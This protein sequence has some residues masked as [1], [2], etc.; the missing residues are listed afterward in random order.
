[1]CSRYNER[2]G[3][4]FASKSPSVH[5]DFNKL[6]EVD[7][8][9]N[10][11]TL[12]A[13]SPFQ[14]PMGTPRLYR[15]TPSKE[16]TDGVIRRE[17]KKSSFLRLSRCSSLIGSKI[18]LHFNKDKGNAPVSEKIKYQRERNS[19][20]ELDIDRDEPTTSC[21]HEVK[22]QKEFHNLNLSGQTVTS[23][24]VVIHEEHASSP[25]TPK[26]K[27]TL[28]IDDVLHTPSPPST[29]PL[30]VKFRPGSKMNGVRSI[31]HIPLSNS[32]FQPVSSV[33]LQIPQD[34]SSIRPK[35]C[36]ETSKLTE[37]KPD[38]STSTKQHAENKVIA[39]IKSRPSHPQ[40]QRLQLGARP[41]FSSIESVNTS[42]SSNISSLESIRSSSSSECSS[43][44]VRNSSESS[45]CS[46]RSSGLNSLKCDNDPNANNLL[47]NS[48][49]SDAQY[50][51]NT[52]NSGSKVPN[53][54][55]SLCRNSELN[56]RTKKPSPIME[57]VR[58]EQEDMDLSNLV[59]V[60]WDMPKL[61]KKIVNNHLYQRL[62]LMENGNTQG[63][64][65]G[66]SIESHSRD[67]G[68]SLESSAVPCPRTDAVDLPFDMP[69]LRR[70]HPFRTVSFPSASNEEQPELDQYSDLPFDMPKLRRIQQG[71][72]YFGS[73]QFMMEKKLNF[74]QQSIDSRS[75]GQYYLHLYTGFFKIDGGTLILSAAIAINT[76]SLSF[77]I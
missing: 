52:E 5:H 74:N 75:Q 9:I 20:P 53:M 18:L 30:P 61:R 16:S 57:D 24:K 6:D 11:P 77:L 4:K 39:E 10:H 56:H 37:I 72:C 44:S 62:S 73:P 25:S 1:M 3:A 60:P 70:R 28:P 7:R 46:S 31:S 34:T 32:P 26:Q 68:T 48:L 69:K 71:Q 33:T 66:I 45:R 65:S 2:C 47:D 22:L 50:Q 23:T 51:Q 59:D 40:T 29:A 13:L 8:V 63:S 49:T 42:S 14:T 76:P 15:A 64:D 55:L 12:Q 43:R 36:E 54:S 21:T 27:R 38:S 35:G 58:R 19:M 17:K 41:K 67:S